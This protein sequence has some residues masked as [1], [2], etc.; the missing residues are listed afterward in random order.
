MRPA[1]SRWTDLHC[2]PTPYHGVALLPEL[3]RQHKYTS[4]FL[5]FLQNE[6]L[7]PGAMNHAVHD[8]PALYSAGRGLV[9][10]VRTA[11]RQH[12][13]YIYIPDLRFTK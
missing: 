1:R 2:R 10:E 6:Y 3:Q 5:P 13:G 9:D 4:R 8:S 7:V 11:I 12:N